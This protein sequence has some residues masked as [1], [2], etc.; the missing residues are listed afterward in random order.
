MLHYS[1][2]RTVWEIIDPTEVDEE[3]K[4]LTAEFEDLSPIAIISDAVEDA[5]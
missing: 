5:E 2:E 1:M 4:T 3:A